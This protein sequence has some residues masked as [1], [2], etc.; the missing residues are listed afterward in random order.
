[1]WCCLCDSTFSRFS[2]TMTC[3][4]QTDTHTQT[5]TGPWLVPRMHS[6]NGVDIFSP[7]CPHGR[8]CTRFDT[9]V[10]AADVISCT[11]F[12]VIGQGARVQILGVENCHLPLTKPVAVNTPLARVRVKATGHHR[13]PQ[14]QRKS[15]KKS[16]TK[17]G[18][19]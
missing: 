2:R 17:T 7:M 5:D 3:D 14:P 13:T 16:L 6:G 4:R 12:V 1:V 11:K 8:I 15:T 10:G 19:T 18:K 9:V